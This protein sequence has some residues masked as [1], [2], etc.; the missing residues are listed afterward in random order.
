MNTE[1]ADP[2]VCPLCGTPNGCLNLGDKDTE[3]TCWCDDPAIR[4]PEQ[5]LAQIPAG[6]RG[7]ACVCRTC[8]LEFQ[9]SQV[10]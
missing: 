3:L 7:K 10:K 4:F 1:T 9:A 2:L 6:E 8:A 5:L